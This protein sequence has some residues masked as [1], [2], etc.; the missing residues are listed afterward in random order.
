MFLGFS[1]ASS[2]DALISHAPS[3]EKY[4]TITLENAI[5][6]E[7]YASTKVEENFDGTIP[8]TWDFDTVLYAEF[9][10]NL[11]AGNVGFTEDIVESVRIKV[12][13]PKDTKFKTIYIKPINTNEDFAIELLDYGEPVGDIEYAYVPVISGGESNYIITKVK[14]SFE[15]YFLCEKDQS[16][17]MILNAAYN[18]TVNYESGQVKPLGRKYPVT[19]VNGNTG[20]K[21]GDVECVFVDVPGCEPDV[22]NNFEYRERVYEM[23]TNK[24]P[25]IL[26][27]CEGNLLMVN[28]SSPISESDRQYTYK[29]K[30]GFYYVKS[31]FSWTECGDAYDIGDLYDNNLIDTDIDR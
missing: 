24:Q 5:F 9:N 2:S 13:T 25:K 22:R 14:S 17:P 6:D 11:T 4:S 28:V 27:D 8:G 31:K 1:L 20:Y 15:N 12:K 16:Y 23:L 3:G 26:K 30:D 21:S 18:Q 10:G 29:G 7:L 19:V